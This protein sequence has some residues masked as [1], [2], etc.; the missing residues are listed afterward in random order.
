M[1][2]RDLAT[3]MIWF[4]PLFAWLGLL[5]AILLLVTAGYGY[6]LMKGKTRSIKHHQWLAATTIISGVIHAILAASILI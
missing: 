4:Q 1:S 6:G 2:L 3:A 5:T